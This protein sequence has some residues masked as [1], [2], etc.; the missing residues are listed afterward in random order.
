MS[1]SNLRLLPGYEANV[2]CARVRKARIPGAGL[3]LKPCSSGPPGL[4]ATAQLRHA[5]LVGEIF[6]DLGSFWDFESDLEVCHSSSFSFR[7]SPS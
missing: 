1:F 5:L 2:T 6:G 7:S 3:T 4:T